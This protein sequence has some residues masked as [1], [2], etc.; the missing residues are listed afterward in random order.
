MECGFSQ[1]H[2]QL[3]STYM[4]QFSLTVP[5]H[6][7]ASVMLRLSGDIQINVL[8]NLTKGMGTL[9]PDW[10]DSRFPIKQML[11]GLV[12]YT[13]QIFTTDFYNR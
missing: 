1:I 10:S 12:E 2:Y 8:R 11:L 4:G 9:Q 7:A 6:N 13:T 3:L 5:L